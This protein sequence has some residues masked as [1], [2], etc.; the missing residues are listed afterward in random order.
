MRTLPRLVP[1][2]L[3]L[4]ACSSSTLTTAGACVVAVRANGVTYV[5]GQEMA[6]AR[7]GPEYARTLR[8][9]ECNDTPEEGEVVEGWRDGDSS[10]PPNTPLYVSLDHP[11]TEL[12]LVR[13][14]YGGWDSFR[15]GH[16]QQ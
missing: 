8:W 7:P 11:P 14:S 2:C 3:L 15:R 16:W 1:L 5:L 6:D 4:A 12:I 13:N 9:R 10:L